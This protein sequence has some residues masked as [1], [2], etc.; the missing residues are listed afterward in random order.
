MSEHELTFRCMGTD[1]RLLGA[2]PRRPRRRARR[3]WRPSTPA[4][5]RF[6]PDER[7]VRA[8]SRSA[9]RRPGVGAAARGGRAPALWAARAHRRPRRPDAAAARCAAPATTRSLAGRRARR[10]AATRSP[11]RRRAAPRARIRRA[12]WRRVRVDDAARRRSAARRGVALDT[13]GTGKGLAADAVAA[14]PRAR[15]ERFAVDCGGDLRV[16]GA[17]AAARPFEVEV[18]HPLRRRARAPAVA[19][20]R[21]DRH[22]GHRRAPVA[23]GPTGVRAPPPRPR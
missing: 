18:A 10:P 12:R 21:R 23:D 3:G 4:L 19:G 17:G 11:R 20:P 7:A 15:R 2:R 5:S 1:V 16:G 9:R 13:G 8:Q 22:L 14:P 6:R